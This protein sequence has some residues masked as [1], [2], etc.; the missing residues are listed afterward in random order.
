[1]N[2]LRHHPPR[3]IDLFVGKI[4][5]ASPLMAL[6]L[7]ISL[8]TILWCILLAR[9]QRSGLDKI[10][11]GLLGLIAI[12][13]A[14]RILKDAG[15]IIFPG[16]PKLEGWADFIIA[17]L[18]LIAALIL[19]VSSIDRATTKAQLRLV[20]ANEK[21]V[22]LGK[23]TI[24]AAPELRPSLLDSCPLATIAVD[25]HGIVSYWNA[26]AETLTGLTRDEVVGH[27][28]PFPIHGPIIHKTG[29]EVDAVFWTSPIQCANGT[30]RGSLAVAADSSA[31]HAAGIRHSFTKEPVAVGR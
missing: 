31:L 18:S 1:M 26:A 5:V 10:L 13:E 17:T 29:N 21:Q 23:G 12:Y 3:S 7:C 9:R 11:T 25:L 15:F 30:T 24:V 22:E 19:R 8:A 20:E 2:Q 28:L 6:A 4:F 27:P 14:V 16:I